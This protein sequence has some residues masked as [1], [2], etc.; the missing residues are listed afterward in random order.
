MNNYKIICFQPSCGTGSFAREWKEENYASLGRK[1]LDFNPEIRFFITGTKVDFDK[2][3]RITYGIGKNA[4]NLAGKFSMGK[5]LAIIRK[6][7]LL[8]CSNTGILHMA[9]AIGTK[10]I[11]L[12]GPNNPGQWG[13]YSKN[14]EVILSDIFCSPCLYLGHEYGCNAPVCMSRIKVEDVYLKV[15]EL[16]EKE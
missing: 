3:Q 9:A 6:T 10:T 13:A 12:H 16:L 1:I 11:G 7:E 5:D 2:C 8:I 14:A 15:R 4:E